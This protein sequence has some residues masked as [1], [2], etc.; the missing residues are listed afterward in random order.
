MAMNRDQNSELYQ[1]EEKFLKDLEFKGR[2]QNTLK[3]YKTDLTCF[4]S[5][6]QNEQN[7]LS[8]SDFN[9]AY[10]LE[11]EKFLQNKYSSNNSKRRRVQ[12]LRLFFDFLVEEG[13]FDNNPIRK[14]TSSPKF[15]DVPKPTPFIDIKTL[16]VYLLEES[17]STNPLSSLINRRNQV[18]LLMIFGAGLKVSDLA[19]LTRKQVTLGPNPRVMVDPP[20]RDPYS[21]PLPPI[22]TRI[23][24]N[25]MQALDKLM[26]EF[27]LSFDEILFSAN[28]YRILSGGLSP[29]GL[30]I[31]FEDFRKKLILNLTPKS[32]RQACIFKWLQQGKKDSQ[33]KEWLGVSPS[34]TLKTYRDHM[35]EHA[36]NDEFLEQLY[37]HYQKKKEMGH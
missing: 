1:W 21:V 22:F 27:H 30:E 3:N 29:R 15:L 17:S 19:H 34:Y 14:I 28:P 13:L 36:Y 37:L 7:S 25:Y 12:T 4:N 32:L 31:I 6:L 11:Y 16:W 24:E 33:I 5:F 35:S 2:S 10:T 20:K 9:I 26:G 18:V 8:L 23:Y